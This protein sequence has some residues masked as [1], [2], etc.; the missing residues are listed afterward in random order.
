VWFVKAFNGTGPRDTIEGVVTAQWAAVLGSVPST[1]DDDFFSSGGTSLQAAIFASKLATTLNRMESLQ[2]VFDQRTVRGIASALR[3]TTPTQ[4]ARLVP[5]N[6]GAPGAP[7]LFCPGAS[8]NL[9]HAHGF[10]HPSFSRPTYGLES[11]GLSPADGPPLLSMS[12]IVADMVGLVEAW[13]SPS[14][15]HVAGYCAG[16]VTA[17]E[18]AAALRARDWDV[19]SVTLLDPLPVPLYSSPPSFDELLRRRLRELAQS[20]SLVVSNDESITAE[21]L[22]ERMQSAGMDIVETELQA[23]VARVRVYAGNMFAVASHVPTS[24]PDIG[25]NLVTATGPMAERIRGS[26]MRCVSPGGSIRAFPCTQYDLV[27]SDRVMTYVADLL[28]DADRP[29]TNDQRARR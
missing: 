16:G 7:L 12:E 24:A 10:S 18:L 11:R 5:I 27:R 22:F 17:Y 15:V 21:L 8:G 28:S 23:F 13:S 2:I 26:W 14:S 9:V 3:S 1:I 6:A 29:R 4:R 20:A 19:R 25:T